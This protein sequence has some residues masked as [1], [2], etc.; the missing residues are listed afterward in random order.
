MRHTLIFTSDPNSIKG[1]L[2]TLEED[3]KANLEQSIS[4]MV[5][6]VPE[7]RDGQ[8]V[9]ECQ[10]KLIIFGGD[11]FKFPFNDLFIYDITGENED[12]NEEEERKQEEQ[13]KDENEEESEEPYRETRLL[14]D[15]LIAEPTYD[16]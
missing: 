14:K 11:R 1:G 2:N 7:P 13:E 10:G 3:E 16:D 5:G 4:R 15:I 8:S 6:E 12:I 9:C